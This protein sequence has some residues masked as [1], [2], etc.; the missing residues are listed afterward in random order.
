MSLNVLSLSL[1]FP[2]TKGKSDVR[3]SIMEYVRSF[4]TGIEE[5]RGADISLKKRIIE[6]ESDDF[7]IFFDSAQLFNVSF[8]FDKEKTSEIISPIMN[9]IF[10]RLGERDWKGAMSEIRFLNYGF[11]KVEKKGEPLTN[12]VR[13]EILKEFS[14]QDAV[15][16]P[17]RLHIRGRKRA[18]GDVQDVIIKSLEKT[19]K[20]DVIIENTYKERFP[21]NIAAMALKDSKDLLNRVL[22]K[23]LGYK[24]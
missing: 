20:I 3:Q 9:R 13:N 22:T 19:V 23:L 14:E 7:A 10:D 12:L 24:Q 18:S 2:K 11:Y 16:V 4:I 1:F 6:V 5:V 21:P 15:F 8:L 17:I